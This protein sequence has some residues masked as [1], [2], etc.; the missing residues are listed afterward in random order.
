M[1]PHFLF[2]PVLNVV[3]APTRVPNRKVVNPATQNRINQLYYSI[4]RL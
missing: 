4:N 2:Y 3:E 1:S